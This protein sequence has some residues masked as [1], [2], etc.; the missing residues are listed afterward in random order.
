[1]SLLSPPSSDVAPKGSPKAAHQLAEKCVTMH[2][3]LAQASVPAEP[4]IATSSI[5]SIHNF[6]P[7][8]SLPSADE[9]PAAHQ[10]DSIVSNYLPNL[11]LH[12]SP[13]YPPST[14]QQSSFLTDTRPCTPDQS[15]SAS[16]LHRRAP[17][18]STID[19]CFDLTKRKK[20][21]SLQNSPGK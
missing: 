4:A 14:P 8:L 11:N 20:T 13:Q 1:M 2:S 6:T 12:S 18:E 15:P 19:L 10:S 5:A 7:P 3:V 21:P 16:H 9:T 17:S